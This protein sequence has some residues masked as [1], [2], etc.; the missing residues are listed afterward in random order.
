MAQRY[1][2]RRLGIQ[3]SLCPHVAACPRF[4]DAELVSG[5]ISA[6]WGP[7]EQ[8]NARITFESPVDDASSPGVEAR[9]SRPQRDIL[10]TD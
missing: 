3:I 2:I 10:T 5:R 9:L 4:A 1:Q 8:A 6:A 7:G